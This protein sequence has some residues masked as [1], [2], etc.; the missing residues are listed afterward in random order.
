LNNAGPYKKLFV[1]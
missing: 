1:E